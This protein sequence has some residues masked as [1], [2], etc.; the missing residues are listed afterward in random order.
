[1]KK[2]FGRK[3]VLEAINSNIEIDQ[4]II[5]LN[6]SGKIIDTI[7]IAAKKHGIK[8]RKLPPAKFK[9]Y[10]N[11][12]NNQGVVAI[13][14]DITYYEPSEIIDAV[15]GKTNQLFLLL[16]SI[17]DTHNLGAILRTAEACGVDGIFTTIHNSAPITDAVHKTSAG[18][19]NHL[20]ISRV[21]NLGHVIEDLKRNNCWIVGTSLKGEKFY[22]DADFNIPLGIVLGNEEKGLRPIIEEHC[23]FLVKI[24]ML[25]KIQ[26]LNVSVSAGIIL[27]EVLRQRNLVKS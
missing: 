21:K 17:Q 20:K 27:Y 11:K 13:I 15:S 12:D 2:I 7:I 25:G 18:A 22:S 19:V 9:E 26:S 4:V 14:S 24:P 10:D 6:Q 23:D 5:A 1:M 8:V 3:P 16:D